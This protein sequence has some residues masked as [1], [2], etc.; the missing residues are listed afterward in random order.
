M[1]IDLLAENTLRKRSIKG[2]REAAKDIGISPATLSRIENKKVPDLETFGKICRWLGDD[3]SI[4][5]GLAQQNSSSQVR[6]HF[7]K[8]SAISTDTAKALS[9]MILLAQQALLNE[10]KE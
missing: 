7:K 1:N 3:P 2:V 8:E 9:Q 4:Y 10:H 5:L 6:V